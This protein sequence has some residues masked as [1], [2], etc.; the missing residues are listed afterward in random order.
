MTAR[1]RLVKV[2]AIIAVSLAM[3]G[4]LF[5]FLDPFD[6]RHVRPIRTPFWGAPGRLLVRGD[7]GDDTLL[8]IHL[9]M[10]ATIR[11]THSE[12]EEAAE[13]LREFGQAR[14]Y[15]PGARS[16]EAVPL[17]AWERLD[18]PS[19]G[20][21]LRNRRGGSKGVVRTVPDGNIRTLIVSGKTVETAGRTVLWHQKSPGGGLVA[22]LSTLGEYL[23]IRIPFHSRPIL[24]ERF[25]E[26]RC[27]SD[28]RRVGRV[29]GLLGT[30]PA[31]DVRGVWS[32]D[33]RSVVYH[34][35]RHQTV[36][37]VEVPRSEN[38]CVE[39]AAAVAGDK[40]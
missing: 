30:T 13:L 20:D 22:V 8:L 38:E 6:E 3:T 16:L 17:D 4:Y 35:G 26:I 40:R 34:D 23:P 32:S 28:G 27:V 29:L 15:G 21:D 10:E 39:S 2:V 33:G 37:V 9:D 14:R 11:W 1:Y 12:G 36:W 31:A 19:Y 7:P 24:G 5:W 25:H 18:I